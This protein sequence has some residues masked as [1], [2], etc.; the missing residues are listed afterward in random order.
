MARSGPADRVIFVSGSL[1]LVGEAHGPAERVEYFRPAMSL[2]QL[3]SLL[4]TDPLIVL[5]TIAYGSVSLVASFFD[6]G[7]ALPDKLAT[8]WGRALLRVEQAC[9]SRPKGS[10]K[11]IRSRDTCS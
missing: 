1:F 5:L 2:G 10:R 11:S 3:R 8:A 4:I 6:S 7:G 9:G